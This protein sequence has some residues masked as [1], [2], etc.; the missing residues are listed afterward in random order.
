MTPTATQEEDLIILSDNVTPTFDQTP[1]VSESLNQTSTPLISFDSND[2]LWSSE[3]APLETSSANSID[4]N[5]LNL[6]SQVWFLFWSNQLKEEPKVE[7]T[8]AEL[9][10]DNLFWNFW[11]TT[12]E[13]TEIE[14]PKLE[15][16]VLLE[17]PFV[18]DELTTFNLPEPEQENVE[19]I[20]DMNSILDSTIAKLQKRKSWIA[21]TKTTKIDT[22]T[23]LES[24]IK[25]L[26]EQVSA[27]KKDVDLLDNES[28][29]IDINISSLEAM[30]LGQNIKVPAKTREHNIKRVAKVD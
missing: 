9:T 11:T 18:S 3:Q 6:D 19:E 8:K 29:K 21:L 26:R 7:Q 14:L 16:N 10:Q 13:S 12:S 15:S 27:L 25:D 2:L 4:T 5:E 22:I 23:D 30:K 28:M 24:Q 1:I 17:T 20:G